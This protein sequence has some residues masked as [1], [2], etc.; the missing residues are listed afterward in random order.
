MTFTGPVRGRSSSTGVRVVGP[1]RRTVARL[2][3]GRDGGYD[4]DHDR[5]NGHGILLYFGSPTTVLA[6]VVTVV[7][8]GK[9]R[10][11]KKRKQKTVIKVGAVKVRA[12]VNSSVVPLKT[13]RNRGLENS[14]NTRKTIPVEGRRNPSNRYWVRSNFP[15]ENQRR[16]VFDRFVPRITNRFLKKVIDISTRQPAR[17]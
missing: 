1:G 6:C 11:D 10:K 15:P 9:Y 14:K 5:R 12:T 3:T 4:A 2:L 8:V 13:R 7:N 17:V 16:R